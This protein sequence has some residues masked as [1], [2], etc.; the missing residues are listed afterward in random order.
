MMKELIS[1]ERSFFTSYHFVFVLH[2]YIEYNVLSMRVL[3]IYLL[4]AKT[5]EHLYSTR[6]YHLR[7]NKRESY[8]KSVVRR[9]QLW[10]RFQDENFLV[11]PLELVAYYWPVG[12]QAD[13]L[14][15]PKTLDGPSYRL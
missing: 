8:S 4:S 12:L 1:L 9:Y 15:Q 10:I 5:D 3:V 13:R 7:G 6:R 2:I 14:R 11:L